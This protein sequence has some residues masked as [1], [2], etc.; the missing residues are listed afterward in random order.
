MKFSPIA[1][2][3]LLA[4]TAS[5]H[6]VD[7]GKL[8][9]FFSGAGSAMFSEAQIVDSV[10]GLLPSQQDDSSLTEASSDIALARAR[11]GDANS[12]DIDNVKLGGRNE[13][14]APC[15]MCRDSGVWNSGHHSTA[16]RLWPSKQTRIDTVG[17]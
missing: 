4:T 7:D 11:V 10:I 9:G 14:D 15:S 5:A 12:T 2:S 16:F 1:I 6:M 8:R 13:A 17:K 3:S